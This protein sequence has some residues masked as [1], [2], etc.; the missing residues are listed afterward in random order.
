MWTNH[1]KIPPERILQPTGSI[2][3]NYGTLY[4]PGRALARRLAAVRGQPNLNSM[5]YSW[6]FA[7][8]LFVAAVVAGFFGAL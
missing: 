8:L 2:C 1:Q 5:F 6:T 4:I 3:R 7:L